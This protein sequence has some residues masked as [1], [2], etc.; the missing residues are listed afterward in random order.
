MQ[1]STA[2]PRHGVV[3]RVA[4]HQGCPD[5]VAPPHQVEVLGGA[6]GQRRM[7]CRLAGKVKRAVL[8]QYM[9]SAGKGIV[10]LHRLAFCQHDNAVYAREGRKRTFRRNVGNAQAPVEVH[11]GCLWRLDSYLAGYAAAV[12]PGYRREFAGAYQL[13]MKVMRRVAVLRHGDIS[14]AMAER[15]PDRSLFVYTSMAQLR[16]SGKPLAPASAGHVKQ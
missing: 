9:T 14:F 11:Q 8:L 7:D 4:H 6:V 2:G 10:Q 16:A 13:G 1:H 3:R 5:H 12:F 15:L